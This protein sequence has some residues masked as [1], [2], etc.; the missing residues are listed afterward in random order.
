LNNK[1]GSSKNTEEKM[2]K[3]VMMLKRKKRPK[4]ALHKPSVMLK[5]KLRRKTRKVS[6]RELESKMFSAIAPVLP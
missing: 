3:M 4:C 5:Q 2:M 1:I 6:K